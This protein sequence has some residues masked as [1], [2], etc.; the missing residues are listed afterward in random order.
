MLTPNSRE[1]L[2][3]SLRPDPGFVLDAAVGT[4]F[5]LDLD[6]LLMAPLSF[7]LFDVDAG[8]VDGDAIAMLAAIKSYADKMVLYTDGAHIAVPAKERPLMLL[9]ESSIVPVHIPGGA[10]HPKIWVLRFSQGPEQ[11]HRVL[12]LS[13]NLTFDRSW[14][15]ILR[16]DEDLEDEAPANASELIDFLVFLG[17]RGDSP[18]PADL[19]GTLRDVAFAPPD[20]YDSLRFWPLLG[21]GL[22][23]MAE[24][25]ATSSLVVSPFVTPGRLRAL[26]ARAPVR[27]LVTRANTLDELGSRALEPWQQVFVLNGEADDNDD[28]PGAGSLSGLH[29]KVHIFDDG[30]ERRVFTGSANATSAA[31][32][33][34]VE[35]VVEL[36]T[37][38]PGSRVSALLKH[39]DREPTLRSL[40]LERRPADPEPAEKTA[41]E[42]ETERLD[43]L[44]RALAARPATATAACDANGSWTVAFALEI[45]GVG[46]QHGDRLRARLVTTAGIWQLLDTR[47]GAATGELSAGRASRVTRLVAVELSGDPRLNVPSKSF[48]VLAELV[49]APENRE[50][51]LLLDLIPDAEKLMRLLFMMLADGHEG[52]EAAGAVR[53]MLA[54]GQGERGDGWLPELPL[55]ENLVRTYAREPERLRG[56]RSILEQLRAADDGVDR[57]PEGLSELWATFES[58]LPKR[59]SR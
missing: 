16:L 27:A 35:L 28:E 39:S 48:V 1:L 42:L 18:I 26:A 46:L 43:T 45:D 8:S 56:I 9:L 34:N 52:P 47:T 40:L 14:D 7:A 50:Q 59:A 38:T 19:I 10:F 29:A 2:L 44:V 41:E 25:K 13:R 15:T 55:F 36:R 30:H 31:V 23:P 22:D 33:Q 37:S 32:Q 11:R 17:K 5:S 20:H 51:Q 3:D 6:A 21:N 54:D 58:A 24:V 57:F 53:R 4:S 12:V 49:D